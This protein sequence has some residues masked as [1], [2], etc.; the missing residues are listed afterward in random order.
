MTDDIVGAQTSDRRELLRHALEALEKMQ[1]KL[2]AFEQARREPIAVIGMG[3]R[4]PGGVTT[5]E[6]YWDLLARGR[7]AITRMPEH[8]WN[9]AVQQGSGT[10]GA[11]N[12]PAPWGGFLEDID[13]FDAS[14]FGISRREA[15]S[16]D[17]Q[18]RLLLEVSWEAIERAGIDASTLR[19]SKT[20]VFVGVTT[21]DY[22]HIALNQDPDIAGCLYRYRQ[23]LECYG[24]SH[25]LCP[26]P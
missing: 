1:K 23:R 19:G 17:P 22:S 13:R 2:E 7:D 18:Q 26:R 24:G 21:T 9:P 25:R 15:E 16:M 10:A 5:P 20:G 4:L 6:Q 3:C 14:F 12:V 8:R 11:V